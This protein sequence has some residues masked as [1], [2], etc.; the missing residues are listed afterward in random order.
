MAVTLTVVAY[1][2][3]HYCYE[4]ANRHP[5]VNPVALGVIGVILGMQLLHMSYSDYF[6]G[7]RIIHFLLGTATVSLAIPIYESLNALKG[8]ML[9]ILLAIVSG[10]VASI[11]SAILLS[12]WLAVGPLIETSLLAK[13]VTAPIAMGIAERIHASPSLTAVSTVLTGI[14]GAMFARYVLMLMGIQS[15]WIHGTA[16]GIASHGIGVARAFSINQEAGTFATV[17]MGLH[18]ILCAILLPWLLMLFA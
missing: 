2:L 5:L 6:A 1:S 16:I 11:L 13:S 12:R 3:S 7:N 18:G 4:R 9:V 8:R 17:G 14:M 15:W 10:G